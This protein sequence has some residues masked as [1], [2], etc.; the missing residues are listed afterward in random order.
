MIY[1]YI[2]TYYS[3]LFFTIVE[4]LIRCHP[5]RVSKN[6]QLCT[7]QSTPLFCP[8]GSRSEV[9]HQ[10]QS[11]TWEHRSCSCSSFLE[12]LL[13]HPNQIRTI[14]IQMALNPSAL[15]R[16]YHQVVLH[17]LAT[18]T[19]RCLTESSVCWCHACHASE[20]AMKV[21]RFSTLT[22]GHGKADCLAFPQQILMLL[23]GHAD[24]AGWF[25]FQAFWSFLMS[26]KMLKER[27]IR[28]VRLDCICIN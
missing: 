10:R 20:A 18:T 1:I 13:V 3:R 22:L 26:S 7:Y 14:W 24:A 2:Y 16:C 6:I 21:W 4:I 19:P 11:N 27:V 23:L 15:L 8:T 28:L 12:N 25:W 9:L 17:L 5:C